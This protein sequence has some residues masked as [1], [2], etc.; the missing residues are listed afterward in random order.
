MTL[1]PLARS[2]APATSGPRTAQPLLSD[3]RAELG[4]ERRQGAARAP[5]GRRSTPTD[6]AGPVE[7]GAALALPAPDAPPLRR[8]SRASRRRTRRS[9]RDP[10][11][12]ASAIPTSPPTTRI[13][14]QGNSNFFVNIVNWL[15]EQ[16]NLIA[17]RPKA[18]DDRRVTMTGGSDAARRPGSRWCSCPAPSS[19]SASTPGGG[20]ADEPRAQH[21]HPRGPGRRRSAPTSTSSSGIASA[22]APRRRRTRRAARSSTSVDA[23]E[24]RGGP[25]S[26]PAAGE[27]TTLRKVDNA[28]RLAAP[29]AGPADQTEASGTPRTSPRADVQRVVDEQPK[30]LAAFGLAKPRVTVT[31]RVAG[32]KTPRTLLLGDKNPTGSDLYAKLPDAPR[33]FLVLG[34]PRRHLRP[35]ARS[36]SATRSSSPSIARRSI[37]ST[38]PPAR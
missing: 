9:G 19:P 25:R 12:R 4:R 29:I 7:L 6:R 11:R 32:E 26:P 16:E 1:F 5:A 28:W 37:A 35:K 34:L 8:P 23:D 27:A 31:F 10:H 30:D 13:G 36:A 3:Q 15:A 18:P 24:D 33:V 17:I 22:G 38:S 20:G 2:V 14:F 21:R